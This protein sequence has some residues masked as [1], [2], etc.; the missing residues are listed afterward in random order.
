MCESL[1]NTRYIFYSTAYCNTNPPSPSAGTQK[2][3]TG[4]TSRSL[5]HIFFIVLEMTSR[6]QRSELSSAMMTPQCLW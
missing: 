6:N 4:K 2:H 1:C 5:P 3:M